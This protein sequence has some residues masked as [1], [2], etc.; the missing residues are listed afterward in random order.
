MGLDRG[1]DFSG[2]RS[3]A[4]T[5]LA[6]VT[7]APGMKPAE[8]P[9]NNQWL[10]RRFPVCGYC[11]TRQR[12]RS[13]PA[14][15]DTGRTI[16]RRRGQDPAWGHIEPAIRRWGIIARPLSPSGRR[17]ARS[18]HFPERLGPYRKHRGS[19]IVRSGPYWPGRG[20]QFGT[21]RVEPAVACVALALRAMPVA[22]R[23]V[24]DG[25]MATARTLIDMAA[26][27]GGAASL[28]GD[29]HFDVQPG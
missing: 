23:I 14:L 21:P 9:V 17:L 11:R 25:S 19:E 28:D 8:F 20:Q 5:S 6:P 27:R 4:G 2:E 15:Q 10:S 3:R 1:A 18:R 16:R 13:S 7:G 12:E 24:G 22:A 26:Q 29:Q